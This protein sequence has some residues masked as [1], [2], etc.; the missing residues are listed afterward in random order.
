M[1]IKHHIILVGFMASGKSTIG[2]MLAEKINADFY[3]LDGIIASEERVSI[4][5]IFAVRGERYFRL[6]EP[7]T[8]KA[9]LDNKPSVIALGGGT[10]IGSQARHLLF[11]RA[12]TIWI[13]TNFNILC[14][15]LNRVSR[16]LVPQKGK[17]S[18]LLD[19]LNQ[20][21]QNIY[22]KADLH[23]SSH[24]L[25]AEEAAHKIIKELQVSRFILSD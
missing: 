23:V 25:T 3:D 22:R 20:K 19:K 21:R 24:Q 15:R 4:G 18:T 1:L 13:Q 6:I 9:L 8:L 16:P 14:K 12:I 10:F 11:G 5:K 2:R 17:Y 7:K